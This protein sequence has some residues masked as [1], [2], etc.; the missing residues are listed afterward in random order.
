MMDDWYQIDQKYDTAEDTKSEL[1]VTDAK[2]M[3][4]A[5]ARV[6]LPRQRIPAYGLHGDWFSEDQIAKQRPIRRF[7]SKV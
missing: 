2:N 1:C 6:V 4:D 7:R 3:K 5:V